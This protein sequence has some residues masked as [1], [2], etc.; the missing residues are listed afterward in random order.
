MAIIKNN[1]FVKEFIGRIGNIIIRHCGGKTIV[2]QAPKNHAAKSWSK[3]QKT[4]RNRFK[5]ALV[6]IEIQN[7]LFECSIVQKNKKENTRAFDQRY[8][9]ISF[10]L[11]TLS[12]EYVIKRPDGGAN[13]YS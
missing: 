7:S 4:N 3:V 8:P 1:P 2:S 10:I 11:N 9:V 6:Q 5:M 12:I 13:H